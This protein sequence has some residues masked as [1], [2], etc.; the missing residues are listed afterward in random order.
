MPFGQPSDQVHGHTLEGQCS[1][2]CQYV[3]HPSC[4]SMCEDLVLLAYCASFYIIGDPFFHFQPPI[5][6]LC[7]SKCFISTWVSCCRVIMHQGHDSSL[8][9]QNR[10]HHNLSFHRD[11]GGC[12]DKFAVR[13]H[14]DVLIV[15]FALVSSRGLRECVWRCVGFSWYI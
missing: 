14:C 5:P 11:S 8:H 6:F 3:I 2:L 9:F 7:F 12:C 10:G 13:E 1:R 4:S 15:H